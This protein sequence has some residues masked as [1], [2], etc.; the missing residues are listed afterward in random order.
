MFCAFLVVFFL[1]LVMLVLTDLLMG[2]MAF[3]SKVRAVLHPEPIE[4]SLFRL[5]LLEPNLG[6]LADLS[7][8]L[9]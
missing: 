9:G 5:L 4:W 7:F 6:T 3:D 2:L 1:P 8:T